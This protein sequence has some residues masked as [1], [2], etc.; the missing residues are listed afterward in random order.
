MPCISKYRA[1]VLCFCFLVKHH[2]VPAVLPAPTT[3]WILHLEVQASG[4]IMTF[5]LLHGPCVFLPVPLLESA[6]Y[7]FQGPTPSCLYSCRDRSGSY[8]TSTSSF[9]FCL[10]K[11]C[12]YRPLLTRG[13]C[14]YKLLF[15]FKSHSYK[16]APSWILQFPLLFFHSRILYGIQHLTEVYKLLLH[17]Y[18]LCSAFSST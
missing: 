16:T 18:W 7:I 9:F 13:F 2:A 1:P 15:L 11:S 4:Q 17:C 14:L 8:C 6:G 3:I 5:G 10:S 12:I